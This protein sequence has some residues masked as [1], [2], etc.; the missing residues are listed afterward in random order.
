M[1]SESSNLAPK[2]SFVLELPNGCCPCFFYHVKHFFGLCSGD[3]LLVFPSGFKVWWGEFV[4]M[5]FLT[6]RGKFLHFLRARQIEFKYRKLFKPKP[7]MCCT[8]Q[9]IFND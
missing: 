1:H 6:A 9:I 5:F 3:C 8:R 7:N 4:A 2:K